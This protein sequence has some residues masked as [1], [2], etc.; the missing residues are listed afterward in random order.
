MALSAEITTAQSMVEAT[1]YLWASLV[2][3]GAAAMAATPA[4]AVLSPIRVEA[5]PR[6][7]RMMESSGSPSPIAMP[8]A[9]IDETA[10]TS[11]GQWISSTS[12]GVP[13]L[14]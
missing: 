1:P 9:E 4:I 11:D 8:T 5:T 2:V 7:S 3:T 10:A 14:G 12:P 13:F 6:F